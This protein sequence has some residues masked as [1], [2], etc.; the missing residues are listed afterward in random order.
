MSDGYQTEEEQIEAIKK[1]WKENGTS[2]LVGIALAVAA[3]FG[4]QGWQK[5]QQESAYSASAMYQN[6][7]GIANTE[8]GQLTDEQISTANHLAETLKTDFRSSSYAQFAALYKAK[9]A[10]AA[11]DLDA[12]ESELRW[13]LGQSLDPEMAAQTRLRLSRV[14]SAKQQYDE[15]MNVLS[16]DA[17]AYAALYD[18]QKG[19]IYLAQGNND[20]ARQAYNDA[21][22]K[23]SESEKQVNN[24]LLE[25][26]LQQL[27][28]AEGA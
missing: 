24:A 19:D 16:G 3:V 9:F 11:N 27:K 25:L 21:K 26:K 14:L 1:W 7:I 4:W 20:S 5:Q 23:N 8:Q 15:A 13:V 6:L 28:I 12:A 17:L 18:E 10:V 22:Q 2:T